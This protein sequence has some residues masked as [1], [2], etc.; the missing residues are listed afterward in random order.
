MAFFKT[1]PLVGHKEAFLPSI[2]GSDQLKQVLSGPALMVAA[3]IYQIIKKNSTGKSVGDFRKKLWTALGKSEF[4]DK[5]GRVVQYACRGLQGF[6]AHMSPD[7]WLQAYKPA[8][9]EVQTTLAW[10]RRSHR[11]GKELPHIPTLGE[12][13]QKGDYLEAGGKAVLITFL[14]QDHIYFLLKVGI[15]KFQQYS[16]IQWHRRNL[17]FIT[18]SHVFN[19]ALCLRAIT[20]IKDKQKNNDPSVSG[21]AEALA[22]ADKE[23]FDNQKMMFRYVLTFL[24]MIHVSGVKQLDDWYVGIMGMIS[25]GI[26]AHKQW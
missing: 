4:R 24:Q 11:W 14:I 10:A 8:I 18:V 9:A 1:P 19:F 13:L 7:F 16:A 2:A 23:I 6:L 20:R 12:A 17:R 26:D 22:K 21:S 15:L 25:S 5:V 3:A